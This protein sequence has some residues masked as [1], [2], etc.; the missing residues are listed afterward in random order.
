MSIKDF[1]SRMPDT[2]GEYLRYL[3]VKFALMRKARLSLLDG[4]KQFNI[5]ERY[6]ELM[7]SQCP[8]IPDDMYN[9]T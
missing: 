3:F 7:L 9:P 6:Y 4:I 2:P 5:F 8:Y 1:Y